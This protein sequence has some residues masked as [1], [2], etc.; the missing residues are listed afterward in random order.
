MKIAIKNPAPLGPNLEKWGDFHFGASL[1]SALHRLGMEVVQHYWPDWEREEGEDAAIWLRGKRRATPRAGVVNAVWILSHPATVTPSELEGFDLVFAGSE[2][3][4]SHLEDQKVSGVR[5][6][7]Q[8]TD[9]QIFKDNR[10][11]RDEQ[12]RGLLF[13]AS[14]RGVRRPILEWAL[15]AGFTPTVI[16]QGW[17]QVGHGALTSAGY[18]PN[19]LL[20]DLYTSAR[21]GMN[22]HWGDMAYYQIINNRVF[23]CMASGLPVISDGFQELADVASGAVWIADGP[24]S[25]KDA[26]WSIRL[27]Y[28]GARQSCDARWHEIASQYTFDARAREIVSQLSSVSHESRIGAA[29][30]ATS[31]PELKSALQDLLQWLPAFTEPE[32]RS[33]SMLHVFPEPETSGALASIGRLSVVSAG[34]GNG[35]WNMRLDL[36][37]GSV[38]SRKFDLIFVDSGDS[39]PNDKSGNEIVAG[40]VTLLKP[41]GIIAAERSPAMSFLQSDSRVTLISSAPPAYRRSSDDVATLPNSRASSASRLS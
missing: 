23:D 40:L 2:R 35:P 1:E 38:G 17:S 27:D 29:A 6:L 36:G 31:A 39:A 18:L 20:P 9:S 26:Y 33:Q 7:R 25:F 19:A 28:A 15:E 14:S 10:A 41:G 4:A 24:R 37:A 13:L 11:I 22:D 32:A 16:G 5:I 12:R 21:F 34:V 30:Q 8:C 3:L